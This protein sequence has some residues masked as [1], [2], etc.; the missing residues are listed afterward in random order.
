[1]VGDAVH[2]RMGGA[3]EFAHLASIRSPKAL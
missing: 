2:E 1:V 3:A